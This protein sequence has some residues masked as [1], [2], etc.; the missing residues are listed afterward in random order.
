MCSGRWKKGNPEE[1]EDHALGYSRGGLTTKIHLLCDSNGHPLHVHI[2]PGQ[3]HES[4]ALQT[5]LEGVEVTG[6][7]AAEVVL[8]ERLTGDKGFRADWIDEYLLD[9]DIVPVIPSKTNE[10]RDARPVEFDGAA[11]KRRN[12]VERLIGWLK[13]S[14]RILT[15]F[16]KTAKNYLGMLKVAFIHRYMRLLCA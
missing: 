11:Y 15:R 2:T 7:E 9:L 14:R 16:E 1:P 4:Q 8:P 13:E 10:D 6:E 12:I 5:L 3:T